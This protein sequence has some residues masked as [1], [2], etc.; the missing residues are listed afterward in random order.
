[1]QKKYVVLGFSVLSVLA[2]CLAGVSSVTAKSS[3]VCGE[4]DV[5]GGKVQGFIPVCPTPEPAKTTS[6]VLTVF[7]P[8]AGAWASVQ[9]LDKDGV[10]WV[11]VPGWTGLLDQGEKGFAIFAVDNA[12]VG[13]GPFR[14]VIYSKDP[15]QG[16]KV[17]AMT[18]K[19]NLP[20]RHQWSSFYLQQGY[21]LTSPKK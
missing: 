16:G 12:D 3:P 18:D 21:G 6:I 2:L 8:P 20:E 15:A 19:F 5:I 13:T 14:W 9:W 11:S 4:L 7:D 1:M 10:T 17:W